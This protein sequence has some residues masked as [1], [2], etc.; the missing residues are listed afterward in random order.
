MVELFWLTKNNWQSYCNLKL[1]QGRVHGHVLGNTGKIFTTLW[2][3]KCT[4]C[5]RKEKS[6]NVVD[7]ALIKK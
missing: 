4:C 6:M 1:G 2:S 3:Y 7:E 5:L